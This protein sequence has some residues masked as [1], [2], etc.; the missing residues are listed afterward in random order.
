MDVIECAACSA[1]Q[2]DLPRIGDC[3]QRGDKRDADDTADT[4]VQDAEPVPGL[5]RLRKPVPGH[6]KHRY[7][8]PAAGKDL[9]GVHRA[10]R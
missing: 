6:G 2:A 4:A 3:A 5:R 8:Y 7:W 9:H 10:A 1:R